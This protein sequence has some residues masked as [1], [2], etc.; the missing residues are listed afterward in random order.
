MVIIRSLL[1]VLLSVTAQVQHSRL[2]IHVKEI[3]CGDEV[4]SSSWEFQCHLLFVCL[5]LSE[6][7]HFISHF[8]VASQQLVQLLLLASDLL[9]CVCLLVCLQFQCRF[10]VNL[11]IVKSKSKSGLYRHK[12]YLE[13]SFLFS[14]H[15]IGLL[16]FFDEFASQFVVFSLQ[17]FLVLITDPHSFLQVLDFLLLKGY[18]FLEREKLALY[19]GISGGKRVCFGFEG[20]NCAL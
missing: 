12:K 9:S 8:L 19:D 18:G 17:F 2:K 20:S 6:R 10:V 5:L 13:T 4:S 7:L 15:F 16:V 3:F 14:E 1:Y 11:E